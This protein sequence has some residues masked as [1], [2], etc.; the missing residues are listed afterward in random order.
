MLLELDLLGDRSKDKLVFWDL[1]GGAQ[2]PVPGA[3]SAVCSQMACSPDGR[4]LATSANSGT[5]TLRDATSGE[6]R[7]A[8]PRPFGHITDLAASP[9]GCSLAVAELTRLMIWDVLTRRELGS[10]PIGLVGPVRC[11]FS[12]DG[13]RLAALI[14]SFQMIALFVD[15]RTNPR[16]VP[17]E[18]GCGK[19]LHFAFS[20]DGRTLAGGGIGR[21]VALWDTS[22]GRMLAE[23]PGETGHVGSLVFAPGGKSLIVSSAGHPVLSWH[24]VKAPELPER[25]DGH[26]A[27][28]W[29]LAYTP[30]SSMLVSSADDHS[31][32]FWNAR[33]G[34]L[35]STLKGHDALVASIAISADGSLLVS[36]SFDKTVR[37]WDLPGGRPRAVLRGH[38]DSVRAVALSPDGEF[39]AS[40]GSDK[41]VRVWDVD[42]R[43]AI[44]VFDGHSDVVRALN[45]LARFWDV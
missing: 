45:S 38:T 36:G 10:V 21:T 3:P 4:W 1:S 26:K 43:E 18:K 29:G 9:D 30:D 6:P 5:V 35:R 34:R 32:K 24:I 31:I 25:L 39:V 44:V 28:V 19:G 12:P 15:V 11:Q 27:E 23:F 13:T 17:L 22:S 42:R 16:M 7:D 41:T 14:D 33:D 8:L 37:L 20:P 2:H 40:A